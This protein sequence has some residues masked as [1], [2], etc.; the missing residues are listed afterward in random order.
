[1]S[2]AFGASFSLKAFADLK[3]WAEKLR[4]QEELLAVP[5]PEGNKKLGFRA[6]KAERL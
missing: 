2:P 6:T 5:W 1:M 3:V 4:C